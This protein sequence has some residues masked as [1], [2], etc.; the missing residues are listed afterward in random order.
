MVRDL[1]TGHPMKQLLLFAVPFM[2]GNLLQ[3][4]YNIAD[5]MIVGRFVGSPG[6]AAASAGGEISMLFLYA[7][8]AFSAGGQV[9]ISQH[10]G[11]GSRDKISRSVG[12]LFTSLLIMAIVFMAFA[13]SCCDWMLGLMKVPEEALGYAHDYSLVYYC[14]MIPMFGYNAVSAVLRGMGDSRHPFIFIGIAAVLNVVLDL[15]FVGALGMASFGAALAT[16]LSQTFSFLL[17]L[18]FLYR[19][20]DEFGFEFK[21]RSF[22]IDRAELRPINKI[23]T[24][25]AVMNIAVSI[26]LVF[27]ARFVNSYGVAAAAATA[28]GNKVTMVATICTSAMMTAGNSMIAQNFAARKYERLAKVLGCMLIVGMGFATLL[29]LILILAPEWVFSLFDKDPEVLALSHVYVVSGVVNL[30]GFATRAVGFGFCNGIGNARLSFIGG[31]IDGIAARIGLSLLFGITLGMG[32]SG[33]WLGSAIAG[34]VVGVI[35]L[36]YY[37]FSDWKNRELLV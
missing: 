29:S 11:A 24:P 17:G 14:G 19:H 18:G 23:G 4:A 28:V 10:I 9:V 13:I 27:I 7:A 12:T 15:I 1:T 30:Y 5:M 31:L 6:L 21:L 37:Y 36:F 16:V 33:F 3:Q 34:N 35:V 25:S 26:S 8:M 32:V 2:L 20:R 22:V